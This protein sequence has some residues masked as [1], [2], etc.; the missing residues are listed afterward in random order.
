MRTRFLATAACGVTVAL[1][2]TACGSSGTAS[3]AGDSTATSK[4]LTVWLMDG[5]LTQTSVNAVN[6]AFEKATGAKVKVQIQEW[7]NINTRVST[8]LAQDNPPDVIDIGNTDVPLFAAN[9]ALADI[10][11]QRADLSAGQTWLPGLVDP[12]TIDGKLYAA[13]LF[14]G[15]RAVVYNKTLWAKA[16]ITSPPATFAQFT[17]DL[18]RIGASEAA[19]GFSAM[20]LP[21]QYW[22]AALQFVWDA[23][24]QLATKD[25]SGKWVGGLESPAAQQGLT[26]WKAFQN[27]WSPAASRNTDT[28]TPDQDAL[29][30]QGRTATIVDTGINTI[31]K[32]NPALGS[33]IGTFAFPSVTGSGTTQPV[34]L[35]GSDLAIAAKS[36]NQQLALAYLKAATSQAVQTSA[37]VGTDHWTP[38]STQLLD[39]TKGLLPLTSAAFLAAAHNSVG[40][41]ATPGWATIESDLSINQFFADI[42]T[43]R[44]SVAQAAKDFDAHLDQALNAGQ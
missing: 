16:G 23:G 43:G 13:P 3:G 40:T 8:A 26:A 19:P 44:K 9:G 11:A 1:L 41:P 34:F 17:Q 5:D 28:K 31:L 7:A 42:A 24:G 21:G 25:A 6:A 22:H 2:T 4:T 33:Q 27:A 37:I 15:N 20:Y 30:A 35:G 18:G 14:A 10:T 12:A 29:F 32:D 38:V 36:P 39:S